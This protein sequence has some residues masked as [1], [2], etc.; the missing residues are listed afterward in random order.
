[1]AAAALSALLA[2]ALAG[3]TTPEPPEPTSTPAFTSEAEAFAAAEETYRAYV[4]ALNAVDLSDPETFEAVYALTTGEANAGERRSL[5]TMHAD[6]WQVAGQT[7]IR[8]VDLESAETSAGTVIL[9]VC[10]DVSGVSVL[11]ANGESV[12]STDRPP[13]QASSV[14]LAVGAGPSESLLISAIEG[15]D[16]EC[17]A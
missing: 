17:G 1:V 3:C 6:G 11:D 16:H 5:T 8:S 15:G 7:L 12:V 9:A 4:D 2:L 10:S 13:L 14:T